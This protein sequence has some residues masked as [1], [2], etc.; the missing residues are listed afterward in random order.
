MPSLADPVSNTEVVI[1][2]NSHVRALSLGWAEI[3]GEFPGVTIG[4]YGFRGT[5]YKTLVADQTR[6]VL[7]TTSP[8]LQQ[9]FEQANGNNGDIDFSSADRVIVVGGHTWWHGVDQRLYSLQVVNR[10]LER[11]LHQSSAYGLF[12]KIRALTSKN[13]LFVHAPFPASRQPDSGPSAL[14]YLDELSVLNNAFLSPRGA[15]LMPQPK[16]TYGET[17]QSKLEYAVGLR[18]FRQPHRKKGM[19]LQ[20]IDDLTH[21]NGKYGAIVLKDALRSGPF[22][23]AAQRDDQWS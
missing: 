8:E 15:S 14:N 6:Q 11:S 23:A 3:S 22:P 13:V 17:L 9:Q 16:E 19:P 7:K 20:K 2:G 21:M 5:F 1:I 10:A 12:L 4:F 18:G